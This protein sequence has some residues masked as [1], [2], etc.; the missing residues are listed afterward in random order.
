[1]ATSQGRLQDRRPLSII[2]I[3]SNSIRLVIYEG[4][5]RSPTVLFNE[6]MLAGLGRGI[7]TTGRLD[8]EAVS[9]SMEEFRRFRALSEQAGAES[10]HVIATA[11]AREAGNGAD[12]IRRAEEI[13]GTTIRVLTGREEAYYS[14][15]GVIS[16]F[17]P[18]D[19][20]AGDLGGGSLELIDVAGDKIGEGI[21]LPLGGLRLQDMTRNSTSEAA[22]IARRELKRADF[23]EGGAGRTFYAVGGTWR[24]LARLH[25]NAT[26][27]PLN[28]MHHYELG[29]SGSAQF[30]AQVADGDLDRIKGIER[31]SKT[32]RALLPYGAVVLQEI[33]R[34]MKPARIVVSALGVREGFLY[35]LL[36]ADQRAEDPLISAADELA[37]LRSR[38]VTHARE[39]AR[40]SGETF[41]TLGVAETPDEAR[42]REAACLLADIGWRAH[43]EYRG[44]QSLN[45]IAHA[46]FIGIDHPGR[47][48]IALTN[49]FRHEGIYDDVVS[50]EMRTLAAP[51]YLERA[52]LLGALMRVVYLLSASMPG[53]IPQLKWEQRGDR[54]FTLLIPKAQSGLMGERPEGRMATLAKVAGMDLKL[55][56][57]GG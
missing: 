57:A 26:G 14:A 6:K 8:P 3:G 29:V 45:I 40:W 34:A 10:L 22:K 39:L 1:M 53:L 5:A 21:T 24:N 54:A 18:A 56:V 33:I 37:L 20:I 27:Y 41:A 13:L 4:I 38:S 16:A 48:F 11:A 31:I 17:H 30:L 46:S 25:M 52:K 2:D 42:Y 50:P 28:V 23:L 49:L 7:V 36:P 19:G 47:A 51:R 15:L 44:T 43:P 35:D 55:A 32:R 12:F 9:R